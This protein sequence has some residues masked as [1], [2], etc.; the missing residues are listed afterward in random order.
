M[1]AGEKV[2]G[3]F[4]ITVRNSSELFELTDEILDQMA[5]LVHLSIKI[6]RRLAT[7][8]RVGSPGFCPPAGFDHSRIGVERFIGQQG[9][10]SSLPRGTIGAL[11]VMRLTAGQEEGKWIAQ[12]IDHEIDIY[13]GPPLPRPIA[14]L[15]PVFFGH[16]HYVR[17]SRK[18]TVDH[19]VLVVRVRCQNLEYLLP[20][21]TL[22]PSAAL[23]TVET[24]SSATE[25]TGSD[26]GKERLPRTTTVVGSG[27]DYGFLFRQN[28][29]ILSH[30]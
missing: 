2:S 7:A 28:I 24:S 12:R 15:H 27:P 4:I 3:G 20:D 8:L 16:R 17:W 22:G 25:I 1:D 21:V 11:K 23:S 14:G 30:W 9:I 10:G 13:V 26:S 5:C 29:L 6:A 19:G 18:S